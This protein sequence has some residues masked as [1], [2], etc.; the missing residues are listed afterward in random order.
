MK[1]KKLWL[2][3]VFILAAL[4]V[5]V[6]VLYVN[7]TCRYKNQVAGESYSTWMGELPD[8]MPLNKVAIP[9]S[10]DA[11]T[12]GI[13]W[14][15]RTQN[16]SIK[17]QLSFGARYFDIRVNKTDKG[18]PIYH[19]FFNGVDF[20]EVLSDIKDFIKENPSEVLLLDFQ[21]FKGKSKEDVYDMLSKELDSEGLILHNTSEL[22]DVE[23]IHSLTLG[24]ARGKCIV[25]FGETDEDPSDWVF[26]RNNDDCTK[27]N[28]T[29]DSCYLGEYHKADFEA[30][31]GEAHPKYFDIL[32]KKQ[33]AGTDGI[34]VLQCQFTDGKFIFGPWN[35]ERAYEADMNAYVK[36]LVYSEEFENINVVLR[37]FLTPEKCADIIELNR[38]KAATV[39]AILGKGIVPPYYCI[40]EGVDDAGHYMIHIYESVDNGDEAH[41]ATV[42]W[43]LVDPETGDAVNFW[44]EEF[45]IWE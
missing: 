16:Y 11:G 4:L 14:P 39:V 40:L 27:D 17:T 29:M 37:D 20:T 2:I 15:A 38:H 21:H 1:K 9:G 35:A 43:I 36:D 33:K 10:H 25:F 8:N 32:H 28:M 30:L 26:L 19:A 12:Y 31:T 42:D 6:L 13:L 44:E 5:F 18:Y 24:E 45:N 41:S 34:F 22:S 7:G 3:P 23:F